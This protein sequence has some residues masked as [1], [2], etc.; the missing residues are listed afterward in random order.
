MT[1]LT[2]R[3]HPT[4]DLA[5]HDP[6]AATRS[7]RDPA[8]SPA[9]RSAFL[10][11]T[12][13]PDNLRRAF[14]LLLV[15]LPVTI[16]G[17]IYNSLSIHESQLNYLG[18]MDV[19][20]SVAFFL[21]I[22]YLRRHSSTITWKRHFLIVF[23]LYNIGLMTAY[24][25][26][27][28]PIFGETSYYTLGLLMMALLVRLP[29][30]QFI[31]ILLVI[32][33]VYCALLLR[34]TSDTALTSGLF[35]GT[36]SLILAVL[37]AWF[38]FHREWDTYE[39]G[40]V[41]TQRNHQLAAAITRINEVTAIAA[42]D[43]RSP[44]ASVLSYI[45]VLQTEEDWNKEPYKSTLG[46]LNDILDGTLHL[47]SGMLHAHVAE[48]KT[49]PQSI[50]AVDVSSL[51]QRSVARLQHSARA[52]DIQLH[53]EIRDSLEIQTSPEILEQALDNLI[54]NAV[55]FSPLGSQVHITAHRED[56]SCVIAVQDSGPG[57]PPEETGQLF[58]KFHRGRNKPT[59]GEAS[60]GIGL[61]IVQQLMASLHGTVAYE[62]ASPTGSIFRLRLP[63]EFTV[64]AK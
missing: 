16:I 17:L 26:A 14:W 52:K 15:Y 6:L 59:A 28:L 10:E 64:E 41:I 27:A 4:P 32:H 55:K 46:E 40:R 5:A 39:K 12:L 57:I 3:S 13:A 25:F 50:Q 36:N 48:S 29:P 37:A 61:F 20:C 45:H 54:S 44:I 21:L 2:P 31:P 11:H 18:A 35:N 19:T 1:E 56:S 38:L 23:Y 47:I 51:I 9:E 49:S 30:R 58:S 33:G 42:H 43:L 7:W 22:I 62:P 24:Y 34:F 53:A 63:I 8:I 60:S